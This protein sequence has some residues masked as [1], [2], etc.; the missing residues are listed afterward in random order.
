VRLTNVGV[1]AG[2]HLSPEGSQAGWSRY[3]RNYLERFD[4]HRD[5]MMVAFEGPGDFDRAAVIG[6]HQDAHGVS[7]CLRSPFTV[8]ARVP[9]IAAAAQS[10]RLDFR[11]KVG[12][13]AAAVEIAEGRRY[14]HQI[15]QRRCW[16]EQR[17]GHRW[18]L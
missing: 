8:T 15:A 1:R 11:C 6:A 3:A 10:L 7:F 16:N 18:T 5:R 13:A 9:L 17:A 2:P 4:A 14:R 12:G